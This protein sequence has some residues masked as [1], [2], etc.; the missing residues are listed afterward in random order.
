MPESSYTDT[1]H[2]SLSCWSSFTFLHKKKKNCSP[3]IES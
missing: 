3:D 1:T 2:A